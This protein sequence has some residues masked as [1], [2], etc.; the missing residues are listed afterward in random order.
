MMTGYHNQPEKT[1][2]VEWRDG[3][4]RRFIRTGDLGWLDDEGFLTLAGR[5]KDVI[6]SG[7]LKIYANDLEDA[8][9]AHVAVQESAVVGAPSER[10]G[11]TPVGFVVL[12][13]PDAAT[14][15]EL[16]NFANQR[17]G[18]TQRLDS[19]RIVDALPRNPLGK[20][21]KRDLRAL[22]EVTGG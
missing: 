18:K 3:E 21:L 15:D 17:L 12:K 8:L 2:E 9:L 1:A 22:L 19:V 11:E 7:G 4:G 10:W 6:I 16:R 20:V 14:A 5:R 13:S